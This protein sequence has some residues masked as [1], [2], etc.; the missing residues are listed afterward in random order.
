MLPHCFILFLELCCIL[1]QQLPQRQPSSTIPNSALAIFDIEMNGYYGSDT[2]ILHKTIDG[3]VKPSATTAKSV[4]NNLPSM[5]TISSLEH[6]TKP[7]LPLI[8]TD[9]SVHGLPSTSMRQANLS[10][11][12]STPTPSQITFSNLGVLLYPSVNCI[13]VVFVLGFLN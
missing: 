13:I 9:L 5:P 6:K 7:R 2:I 11:F 3:L 12:K 4:T 1:A 10:T 8:V